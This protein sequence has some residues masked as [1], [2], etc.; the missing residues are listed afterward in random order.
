MNIE[1][2]NR[3][4]GKNFPTFIIAE[5]GINH[6]GN[7]E[8]AK[9]LID[10]ASKAGADA[11][12]FQS[13]IAKNLVTF[14]ANAASYQHKDNSDLKQMDI[15]E[16][17]ELGFGELQILKSYSESK[18]LI[19]LSTPFDLD[20]L[21]LLQ[22]LDLVAYKISSGDL[23][24]PILLNEV[25]KLGKPILLSS[26][27]ADIDEIKESIQWIIDNGCNSFGI[28]Q[29]TSCYP[30]EQKDCNLNVITSLKNS[31][32]VPIGFSDHTID[33]T[34]AIVSIGLGAKF[35][36]KHITLDHFLEGPDHQMSMEPNDFLLYVKSIRNAEQILGD[37]IKKTLPCEQEV[38]KLGRKS[39]VSKRFIPKNHIIT[40]LDLDV[41]RPGTGIS[42]KFFNDILG[43]KTKHDLDVDKV[44]QW[45]DLEN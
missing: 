37:G 4:I 42:P 21:K 13:F 39:I 7:I 8:T 18:D 45:D 36:E 33:S 25:A 41:K 9:K 30:T 10:I 32:N 20:S 22:E 12:K 19:F 2:G 1:I 3:T 17:V 44:L 15:L 24:N 16:K 26:G 11:V 14:T 23:T 34:A 29:C 6:N 35:I 40:K 5:V 28:M 43:K 38:K 27:M 31:F